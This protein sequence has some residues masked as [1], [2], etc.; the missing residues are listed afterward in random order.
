M[1]TQE[2]WDEAGSYWNNWL[3]NFENHILPIFAARG[4]IKNT[5]LLV[6]ALTCDA[7]T[8]QEE[9]N[10]GDEPWKTKQ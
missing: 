10:D 1:S 7:T 6:Y 8:I 3:D 5:A 2:E 4:Y 9:E